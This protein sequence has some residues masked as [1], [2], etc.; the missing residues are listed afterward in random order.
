MP[1]NK[2]AVEFLASSNLTN[3]NLKTA[4]NIVKELIVSGFI[5][6][7]VQTKVEIFAEKAKECIT[8]YSSGTY[9]PRQIFQDALTWEI[10]D[11]EA[12]T[13]TAIKDENTFNVVLRTLQTLD[14]ETL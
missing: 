10:L 2:A 7:D 14:K 3:F 9:T 8:R 11:W 6:A 5:T 12:V 13:N 4:E 1:T